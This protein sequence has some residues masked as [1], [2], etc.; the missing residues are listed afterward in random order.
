MWIICLSFITVVINVR[1]TRSLVFQ[2]AR[3]AG[4]YG[5]GVIPIATSSASFISRMVAMQVFQVSQLPS[6]NFS[7]LGDEVDMLKAL[8]LAIIV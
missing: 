1:A 8:E 7:I 3:V 2:I 4:S 6:L 5:C